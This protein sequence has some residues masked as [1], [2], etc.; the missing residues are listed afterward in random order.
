MRR[1]GLKASASRTSWS[2]CGSLKVASQRSATAPGAP[3]AA[4]HFCGTW[5]FSAASCASASRS[6]GGFSA[7][8][9]SA[10]ATVAARIVQSARINAA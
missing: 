9:A 8:P 6:G 7:H 2:S 5:R 3:P 4:V 1:S 10:A